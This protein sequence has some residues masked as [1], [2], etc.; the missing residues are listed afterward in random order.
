MESKCKSGFTGLVDMFMITLDILYY[1]SIGHFS[2]LSVSAFTS[3]LPPAFNFE[4]DLGRACF[5]VAH[6]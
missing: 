6:Q 5:H 4:T 2:V 3:C 1:D